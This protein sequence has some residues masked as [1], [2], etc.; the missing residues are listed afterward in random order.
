MRP[1]KRY[2][3]INK[4]FKRFLD[5][6]PSFQTAKILK[7][8]L[9]DCKWC[10]NHEIKSFVDF[11]LDG[12]WY[13]AQDGKEGLRDLVYKNARLYPTVEGD[14]FYYSD[15]WRSATRLASIYKFTSDRIKD[16]DNELV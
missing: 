6:K 1:E 5:N 16:D 3:I 10:L 12:K 14:M 11:E 15:R 9:E 4:E 7:V 2:N 13:Y 8:I